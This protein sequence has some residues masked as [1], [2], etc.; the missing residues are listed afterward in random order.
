[1]LALDVGTGDTN[2]NM[3]SDAAGSGDDGERLTL[4]TAGEAV[5]DMEEEGAST[6]GDVS[7]DT[8]ELDMSESMREARFWVL[9]SL[10]M[11]CVCQYIYFGRRNV[12]A[13]RKD[14][15]T[16]PLF[17]NSPPSFFPIAPIQEDI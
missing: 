12:R 6:G 9:V 1:M 2:P 5:R 10:Q 8:K 4:E 11:G 3:R 13:R 16:L 7:A 14:A 17:C 15:H